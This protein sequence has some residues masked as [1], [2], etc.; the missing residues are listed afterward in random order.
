M[1]ELRVATVTKN[2]KKLE[3]KNP[4]S[5]ATA[6]YQEG[7][8]LMAESMRRTPVETGTLQ[9]THRTALPKW[10][11]PFVEVAIPAGGSKAPYAV[12]VHERLDVFHN[13]GQAKFLES[14]ILE[15]APHLLARIGE[16]LHE[17][18]F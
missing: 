15:S 8:E 16:R 18:I 9:K 11:G 12:P 4:R 1:F 13:P 2:L 14:T 17:E 5:V 10:R 6:L 3:R 7:L